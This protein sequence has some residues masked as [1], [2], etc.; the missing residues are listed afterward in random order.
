MARPDGPPDAPD[1]F[2]APPSA[3]HHTDTEHF[4]LHWTSQTADVTEPAFVEQA[5]AVFEEVWQV[6]VEELGWPAPPGDGDLGG[7]GLVD[8]YFVDL[9]DEAYG[10]AAVDDQPCA[11][12][13]ADSGFLVMDNDYAG[14]SPDALGALRSAAAHEFSH[15][16]H[17]GIAHDAEGW[18]YEATA[19]W[20]EQQ[21]FPAVDAR[22]QYLTDF[23][24]RPELALTDFEHGS[25]GFDRAYGL[26][27]WNMWLSSRYGPAVVRDA[28]T[29]AATVDDRILDG[30][31]LA[32]RRRGTSVV[33][34]LLAFTAATA[35]WDLGGF[36]AEADH[37]PK[38]A[39]QPR[40]S[41]GTVRDIVIDHTAA[42]VVD[43]DTAADQ[44]DLRVTV[45]GP[46]FVAGG[47]ALVAAS[48]AQVVTVMD[49]TLFD[50]QAS[51]TLD[52]IPADARVTLVVV[53]GDV[54]L[55]VPK[56]AGSDDVRYLHDDVGYRVG[57]DTD[58]GRVPKR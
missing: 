12:C 11:G 28:W 35:V 23:V 22:T 56:R 42:Y 9:G 18:A 1:A 48:G 58:P 57:I 15:L 55:A 32:L 3:R 2:T 39:R 7:N 16:L 19:V 46:K 13:E 49:D 29:S 43:V 47:V 25:G 36:P 24:G 17:F 51:V 52:G 4:R 44:H 38:V 45:R 10:Y 14:F 6:Q 33:H 27:V 30:Y 41:S 54:S 50:G 34:E 21:V 26:Y 5:A 37:Y 31:D 8:V 20:L 40:V 53:N